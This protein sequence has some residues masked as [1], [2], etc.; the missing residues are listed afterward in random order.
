MSLVP[1]GPIDH[2]GIAVRDLDESID[3]YRLLLGA[4]LERREVVADQGV[5]VAFLRLPGS[6]RL[7]LVAAYGADGPI[8]RFIERRGEG[9]HHVCVVVDDIE[10]TLATLAAAGVP[11][12]D[13]APR[14]GAGGARI[15]FLHPEALDG[16]LVELKQR[17]VSA[18]AAAGETR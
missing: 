18:P 7:E 2:V 14:V 17:A 3:R 13:R 9:M 5:E 6:A 8:A 16:V 15:A 4:E 11:L 12:A 1:A 10:A